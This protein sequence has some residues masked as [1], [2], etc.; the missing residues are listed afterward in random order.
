VLVVKTLHFQSHVLNSAAVYILHET[1]LSEIQV[2]VVK[3]HENQP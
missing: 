2:L 1:K 3:F